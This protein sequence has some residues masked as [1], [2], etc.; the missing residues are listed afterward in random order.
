MGPGIVLF[1]L[2]LGPNMGTSAVVIVR[3]AHIRH[4]IGAGTAAI[5]LVMPAIAANRG[6]IV[7]VVRCSARLMDRGG[8]VVVRTGRVVA[9]IETVKSRF[10]LNM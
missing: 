3:F 10:G 9:R 8:L 7:S 5:A 2:A 6:R 4:S 1:M